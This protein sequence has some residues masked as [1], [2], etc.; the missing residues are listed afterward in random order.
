MREIEY[1]IAVTL[2]GF[3]CHLDGRIDGFLMEG[4][5]ADAF[6]GS[7]SR[8]DTVL[9][10]GK[11]YEFGF[12][13]G[14]EAGQPAYPY[15]NHYVFSRSLKFESSEQVTLVDTDFLKT[16]DSLRQDEGS[17]I[18][19]CGGGEFAGSLLEHGL[20]SKLTLKVNPI[21]LGSGRK[22]FGDSIKPLSLELI[23]SKAFKSGVVLQSYNVL[24]L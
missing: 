3:I 4:D 2:D 11:T 6:H 13:Y 23:S 20:I 18:W 10:G 12:Q 7:L 5:H 19:L 16:L 9:M 8:Y 17:D 15:M 1:Y 22:L 21:I 24:D 14:L